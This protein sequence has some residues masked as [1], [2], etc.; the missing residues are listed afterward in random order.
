MIIQGDDSYGDGVDIAASTGDVFRCRWSRGGH[1]CT[2]AAALDHDLE[3][4]RQAGVA[5][6]ADLTN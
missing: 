5:E 2:D 6:G 4:L 3:G 1:L